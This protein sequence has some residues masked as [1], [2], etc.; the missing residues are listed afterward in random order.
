[1][2]STMQVALSNKFILVRDEWGINCYQREHRIYD[3]SLKVVVTVAAINVVVAAVAVVIV[4]VVVVVVLVV[5][6]L[7]L[8]VLVLVLVVLVKKTYSKLFYVLYTDGTFSTCRIIMLLNA[9]CNS[10]Y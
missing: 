7:V 2:I 1:M 8:V 9:F 4:V 3:L 10:S 6:V 5:L